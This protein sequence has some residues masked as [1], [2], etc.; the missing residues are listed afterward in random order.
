MDFDFDAFYTERNRRLTIPDEDIQA[1]VKRVRTSSARSQELFPFLY[2]DAP[3][4]RVP[5]GS[6]PISSSSQIDV[7]DMQ[8]FGNVPPHHTRRS[9]S[10]E[11]PADVYGVISCSA[12]YSKPLPSSITP[13]ANVAGGI[14][15]ATDHISRG[16][17]ADPTTSIHPQPTC[18][19]MNGVLDGA[20]STKQSNEDDISN[21]V[22]APGKSSSPFLRHSIDDRCVDLSLLALSSIFRL[23]SH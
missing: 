11:I 21:A 19:N 20:T 10:P 17:G 23:V 6:A 15:Q 13:L 7:E 4:A 14:I 5:S 3:Q 1:Y 18:M 2:N 16:C 8:S 22:D 12:E 9:G